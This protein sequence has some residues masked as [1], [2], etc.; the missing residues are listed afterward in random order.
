MRLAIVLVVVGCGGT[1]RA[2]AAKPAPYLPL[3]ERGKAW[4]LD[5][6]V[7]HGTHDAK[8]DRFFA[9]QVEHGVLRCRTADV[10]GTAEARTA[11]VTCSPPYAGLLVTGAW[12]ARAGGL[13]HPPAEPTADELAAEPEAATSSE[14]FEYEHA[15]CVRETTVGT[16]DHREVALCFDGKGVTGGGELVIAAPDEAWHL[17]RFGKAPLMRDPSHEAVR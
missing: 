5:I 16:R 17:A 2:A 10:T 13:Y 9:D 6:D 11:T 4:S 7:T 1:S 15:W 8:S 3:F 14:A 12:V